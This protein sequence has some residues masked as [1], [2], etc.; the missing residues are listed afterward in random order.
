MQSTTDS[1]RKQRE[2]TDGE[3]MKTINE[4]HSICDIVDRGLG[5]IKYC[6]AM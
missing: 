5:I 3:E 4:S 2:K 6:I 1:N